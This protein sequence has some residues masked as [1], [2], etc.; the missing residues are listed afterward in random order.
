MSKLKNALKNNKAATKYI[1]S[2]LLKTGL[3][4]ISSIIILRWIDPET[5][6]S[7]HSF[8]V[9]VGYTSLLSL[10]VTSGLNR[11]LPYLIGQGE[12]EKGIQRLKTA[13]YFSRLLCYALVVLAG[14]AGIVLY[15]FNILN[16]AQVIMM[17]MAFSIGSIGLQTNF[18]GATFRSNSSFE[19][20]AK[21]Q[22]SIGLL[23]LLLLP[24]IYFF[25]IWGYIFYELTLSISTFLGYYFFRPYRVKYSFSWSEFKALVAIGFPMFFWNYLATMSRSIPKLILVVF[26]SPL[27]V[28]LYAPATSINTAM[29]NLPLYI[30]RYL[31]PKLS[32]LYGKN[33]DKQAIYQYTIKSARYLLLLMIIVAIGLA[34]LTPLL[35][36]LFFPKYIDS[37][38]A[39]QI[40]LFSGVFYSVNALFHNSLNSL[41]HFKPFKFIITLRI[42]FIIGFAVLFHSLTH[43]LL[44][45]VALSAATSELLNM[46]NYIYFL[47]KLR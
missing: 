5:I 39:T 44:I 36:K 2:G 33:Q 47:R 34:A 40:I 41:K 31:F 30:N 12:H 3:R 29:L 20:L 42:V 10:G 23:Y 45:A 43:D 13:G 26:G 14:I 18:L 37:V 38:L 27:L 35:F 11:E 22:S 28:G 17:V 15:F 25:G 4:T 16:Q 24:I 32:F 1:G 19:K 46:F 6:G 21:V 9:F 7:W 8:T